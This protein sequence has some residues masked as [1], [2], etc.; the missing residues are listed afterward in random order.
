MTNFTAEEL[1]KALPAISSTLSK[2]EKV[3]LKLKAGTFQHTMT[4]QG[5]HAYNI[6]IELIKRELE[7]NTTENSFEGKYTKEELKKALE[8]I[9]SAMSRVE[10]IQPKFKRGTSQHTL[11]AR[12]IKAFYIA[13]ELINRELKSFKS[14]FDRLMDEINEPSTN[15]QRRAL[16]GDRLAEIGDN[17]PGIGLRTDGLPDIE[18]CDAPAGNVTL[19]E[20]AGT[21]EVQP[22][23][24]ARY[25]ITY[26]Q[27]RAFLE[28]EDGYQKEQWWEGLKRQAKPGQQNRPTDNHPAER[29]SWYEAMAFCR[30]LSWRLET[31]QEVSTDA[32][33]IKAFN[34]LKP[35]MC[36]KSKE[37]DLM[38]PMT[39]AVRLPTECEWQQAATGGNPGNIYPWGEAWDSTK[40]N[41]SE[42]G[43]SRTT[44][45]GM[46][47]Q[48][49][50]RGLGILDMSG[51]VVEWCLS[52]RNDPRNINI[53]SSDPRV[54]RGG[55]WDGPR[56]YA[57]TARRH[58]HSPAPR[59]YRFG[60]RLVCSGL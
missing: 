34:L 57:R 24:I 29:V 47:P 60:F 38:D 52:V 20:D 10:K 44:A 32:A 50:V 30:W 11:A 27:Y 28:A 21:F 33:E 7:A 45:V 22:F 12:R 6:A 35:T 5:I 9:T 19:E 43:L 58:D 23:K 14:E 54:V 49:M 25:P 46:Y 48:G 13:T 40:T 51:N 36:S 37:L 53:N 4:V 1:E 17:R 41:T 2:S 59:H 3:Q 18:W 39:W 31:L 8:T 55:S 42:S 16:I 56:G 15:H 26:I